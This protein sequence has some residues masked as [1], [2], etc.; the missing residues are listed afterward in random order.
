MPFLIDGNGYSRF[1]PADGSYKATDWESAWCNFMYN[2]AKAELSALQMLGDLVVERLD[3]RQVTAEQWP[4]LSRLALCHRL[5]P[6]LFALLQR[7]D[8]L[9][10]PPRDMVYRLFAAYGSARAN[11]ARIVAAV[12]EWS[13]RFAEAGIPAIWLKGVALGISAYPEFGLRPMVDADVLVPTDHVNAAFNLLE[14]STG[15]RPVT[16][17]EKVTKNAT[18]RVGANN[19]VMLEL[20]WSLI[21]AALSRMAPDV[22][23]FLIHHDRIEKDGV[24]FLILQP[25]AHL[26]YLAAHAIFQHGEAD[27]SLLRF[28][29]LHLVIT[30]S[31]AFDWDLAVSKANEFGWSY[32]VE[33]ALVLTHTYFATPI[34]PG[35]VEALQGGHLQQGP[36]WATA[37]NQ[38]PRWD[39]TRRRISQMSWLA[40]TQL[41]AGLLFPPPSYI[42]YRYNLQNNWQALLH[43]PYRWWDAASEIFG[44][45]RPPSKRR[46]FSR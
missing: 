16:L 38:R 4:E 20:H 26:I 13:E 25:E 36:D 1:Q 6:V 41:A 37:E 27:A 18:C 42:R 17:W 28:Y 46:G 23:W 15:V 21:D 10:L 5:G 14:Q 43:Y 19:K 12:S 7:H 29:D 31:P 39:A 30:Q 33:R 34:P 11:N 32:S 3:P 2:D 22:G 44:L 8:C 40:R 45:P 35:V 9:A 24:S